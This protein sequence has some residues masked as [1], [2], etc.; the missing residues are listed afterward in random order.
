MTGTPESIALFVIS[1]NSLENLNIKKSLEFPLWLS[2]LGI[3]HGLCEDVGL[4]PG[5]VQWVKDPVLL[6]AVM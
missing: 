6:Q 3:R 2:G 4:I 1:Q 5:L